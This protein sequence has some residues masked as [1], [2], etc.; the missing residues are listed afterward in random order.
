MDDAK[1]KLESMQK[2]V[3]DEIHSKN[4]AAMKKSFATNCRTKLKTPRSTRRK[5]YKE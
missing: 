5:K 2:P 4:T 1:K 3:S